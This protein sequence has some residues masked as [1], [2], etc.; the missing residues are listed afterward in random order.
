[1]APDKVPEEDILANEWTPHSSRDCSPPLEAI[2]RLGRIGQQPRTTF[3][4]AWPNSMLISVTIILEKEELKIGKLNSSGHQKVLLRLR[5]PESHPNYP[6]TLVISSDRFGNQDASRTG[7]ADVTRRPFP[8]TP[9]LAD[10]VEIQLLKNERTAISDNAAHIYIAVNAFALWMSNELG[11]VVDMNSRRQ[12]SAL[13]QHNRQQ[14]LDLCPSPSS[15]C[16]IGLS[17]TENYACVV[18]T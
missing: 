14:M 1:M 7:R 8:M 15:D 11:S 9:L 5:D 13:A 16:R 2:H 17:D 6:A 3:M 4:D 10:E 18:S 12:G